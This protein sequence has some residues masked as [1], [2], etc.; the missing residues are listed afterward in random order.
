[1]NIVVLLGI[2]ITLAT[3]IPVLTAHVVV[4]PD[5]LTGDNS[6]RLLSQLQSCLADHFDVEHSTFQFE[7][8]GH[9]EPE[10]H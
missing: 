8:A 10:A 4:A 6:V 5:V 2:V 3:G 7:P 1:M 9:R